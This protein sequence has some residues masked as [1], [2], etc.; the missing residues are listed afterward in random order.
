MGDSVIVFRQ[1]SRRWE[2]PSRFVTELEHGYQI[3]DSHGDL[4]LFSKPC[5]GRN[6]HSLEFSKCS[7]PDDPRRSSE[8]LSTLQLD[9]D[10]SPN[11]IRMSPAVTSDTPQPPDNTVPLTAQSAVQVG[12][13]PTLTHTALPVVHFHSKLQSSAPVREPPYLAQTVLP[14]VILSLLLPASQDDFQS[15]QQFIEHEE[16]LDI[17]NAACRLKDLSPIT[18]PDAL[19][20]SFLKDLFPSC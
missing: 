16:Q 15:E 5:V 9:N 20:E 11:R 3:C 6:A 18:N 12:T 7:D 14:N 1:T 4:K 8:P 10:L 13:S 19:V 2:G 17:V